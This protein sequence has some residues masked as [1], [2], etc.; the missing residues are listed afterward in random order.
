LVLLDAPGFVVRL[1]FEEIGSEGECGVEVEVELLIAGLI[2]DL[3]EE[4]FSD[5]A[6][7]SISRDIPASEGAGTVAVSESS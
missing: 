3:E 6:E 5:G 7:A 2:V 4:L 1:D